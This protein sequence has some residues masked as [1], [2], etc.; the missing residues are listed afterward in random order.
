MI[1]RYIQ[2]ATDAT[3]A[4]IVT[5]PGM[6]SDTETAAAPDAASAA[7][8]AVASAA[9]RCCF[10]GTPLLL[11]LLLLLLM[12]MSMNDSRLACRFIRRYNLN[13]SIRTTSVFKQLLRRILAQLQDRRMS[14]CAAGSGWTAGPPDLQRLCPSGSAGREDILQTYI[15]IPIHGICRR[16]N[17]LLGEVRYRGHRRGGV[18]GPTEV[19]RVN[20]RQLDA[21]YSIG[22]WNTPIDR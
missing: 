4:R 13:F 10:P 18:A 2:K 17:N 3:S 21:A 12:M 22:Q 1:I 6:P 5:F 8:P 9:A 11:L 7:A 14:W 19:I 15:R 16:L 20:V